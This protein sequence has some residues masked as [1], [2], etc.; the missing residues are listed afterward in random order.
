MGGQ[1]GGADWRGVGGGRAVEGAL[2][3]CSR[4]GVP[5]LGG[6]SAAGGR[7]SRSDGGADDGE[8]VIPAG[9]EHH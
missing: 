3:R 5:E 6:R 1:R 9:G 2:K 4:L 8:G 7:K